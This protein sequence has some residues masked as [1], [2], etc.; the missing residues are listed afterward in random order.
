MQKNR[1][2]LPFVLFLIVCSAVP[3]F[4]AVNRDHGQDPNGAIS[5]IQRIVQLIKKIV[6]PL[7]QIIVP[8]P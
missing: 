1:A 3:S 7:D 8:R 5:P 2:T 6:K 4:G